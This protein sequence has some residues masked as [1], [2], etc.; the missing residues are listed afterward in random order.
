MVA[1]F[2]VIWLVYVRFGLVLQ[3]HKVTLKKNAVAF[4]VAV[5]VLSRTTFQSVR[6]LTLQAPPIICSRRHFQILLLFQK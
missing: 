2:C 4:V 6:R 3:M 5:V 1:R